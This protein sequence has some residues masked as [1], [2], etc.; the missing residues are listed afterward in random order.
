[1]KSSTG[2]TLIELLV[3]LTIIGL[4]FGFGYVNFRDYSRRQYLTGVATGLKADLRLAQEKAFSGEIP[5]GCIGLSAYR[6][7]ISA[8]GYEILADCAGDIPVKTVSLPAGVTASATLNPVSFKIL[9][10]G[11]NIP[12]GGEA[13]VTLTQAE[14]GLTAVT[15]VTAGGEI[16]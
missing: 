5:E 4:T 14:S 1:M 2:F 3:G 8:V 7:E 12:A 15:T 11:T 6:V 9:G 16:R 13:K 10:N